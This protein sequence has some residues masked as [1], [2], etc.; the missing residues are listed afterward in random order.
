MKILILYTSKHG[1][2]KAYTTYLSDRLIGKVD[3]QN[4]GDNS[5]LSLDGYDW[6]VMGSAVYMGKINK[7]M[8]LFSD[9]NRD[10]LLS[11]NIAL[12]TCCMT[13]EESDKY[14]LT[15]FSKRLYEASKL[16]T[17][18]GGKLQRDKL[19]FF[20]RKLTDLISKT[21]GKVQETFYE[22]MD[23]LVRLINNS[24]QSQKV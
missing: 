13:P 11:H 12:F 14:L 9:K 2:T 17:N 3:V 7:K 22:N 6:I 5:Q 24:E 18:F 20:E 15:G 8:T 4:L 1:F 19:T 16:N 10:R 21:E 23:S